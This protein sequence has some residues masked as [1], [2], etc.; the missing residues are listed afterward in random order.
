MSRAEASR[1][2]SQEK[3]NEQY[4]RDGILVNLDGEVPL[5]E[6]NACYKSCREVVDVVV[7]AGLAEIECT[8]W[9]L[10]SL[11]GTEQG[12]ASRRAKKGRKR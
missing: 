2:L 5:D 1:T 9:P 7:G 12:S 6:A 8:L 11:K 4:R 3:V 10:S